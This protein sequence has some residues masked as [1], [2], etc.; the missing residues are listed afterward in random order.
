MRQLHRPIGLFG[1]FETL[2]PRI[3]LGWVDRIALKALDGAPQA[4]RHCNRKLIH[5]RLHD[6]DV[7]MSS[8]ITGK[9]PH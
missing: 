7:S 1:Q 9:G 6:R 4:S 8:A 2:D 3:D 5:C